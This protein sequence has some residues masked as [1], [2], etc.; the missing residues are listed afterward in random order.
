MQPVGELSSFEWFWSSTHSSSH[1]QS[2][3]YFLLCHCPR[4]SVVYMLVS[5]Q[6]RPACPCSRKK[7]LSCKGSDRPHR[8]REIHFTKIVLSAAKV[9]LQQFASS[10]LT[11]TAILYYMCNICIQLNLSI[12][13]T[14]TRPAPLCWISPHQQHG[15]KELERWP[16]K[17]YVI[18]QGHS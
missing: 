2:H 4:R 11:A 1:I 17:L 5:S 13:I 7:G 14:S 10:S 15:E 12:L 3:K 18:I 8:V 16:D 9:S 6:I